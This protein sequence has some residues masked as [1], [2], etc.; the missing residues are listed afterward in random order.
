MYTV[1]AEN[2][3]ETVKFEENFLE[4]AYAELAFNTAKKC[5]DCKW[6]ILIDALTGEVL[7]DWDYT[8]KFKK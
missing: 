4:L 2:H 5:V 3:V 8:E 1:I 6:A 7:K